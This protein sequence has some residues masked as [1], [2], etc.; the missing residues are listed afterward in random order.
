MN[1]SYKYLVKFKENKYNIKNDPIFNDLLL[2]PHIFPISIE[3]NSMLSN[4]TT[5][6]VSNIN[7]SHLH[8]PLPHEY[9]NCWFLTYST[10]AH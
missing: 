9:T 10:S 4:R 6:L 8:K 3:T 5:R 1:N 2:V 7:I